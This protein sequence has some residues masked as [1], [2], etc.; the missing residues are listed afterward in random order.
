VQTLSG[1]GWNGEQ[2][3]HLTLS[4]CCPVR[5]GLDIEVHARSTIAHELLCVDCC[6]STWQYRIV[7]YRTSRE[8][9][10]LQAAIQ[11]RFARAIIKAINQGLTSIIDDPAKRLD[12]E[13]EMERASDI[14]G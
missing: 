3:A 11:P 4:I 12:T 7:P 1:I 13:W 9:G 6:S 8:C 10:I 5:D 2:N 14:V